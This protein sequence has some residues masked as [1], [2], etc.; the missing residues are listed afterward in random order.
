MRCG[1]GVE[2]EIGTGGQ[3]GQGAVAEVGADGGGVQDQGQ[4]L[5]PEEDAILIGHG[6][7]LLINLLLDV[8]KTIHF[9]IAATTLGTL[10][11]TNIDKIRHSV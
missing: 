2:V 11:M 9:Q 10:R 6:H 8:I 5:G 4:G 1:P 3:G 7:G